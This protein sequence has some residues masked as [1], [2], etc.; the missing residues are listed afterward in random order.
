MTCV[1]LTGRHPDDRVAG[2]WRDLLVWICA[3]CDRFEYRLPVRDCPPE[4]DCSERQPTA[5]RREDQGEG[6]GMGPVESEQPT[7]ISVVIETTG[8]MFSPRTRT[9]EVISQ[10]RYE[11]PWLEYAKAMRQKEDIHPKAAA[12]PCPPHGV[13][14]CGRCWP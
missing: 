6:S 7:P 1:N 2:R 13:P 5:T 9:W 12:I 14:Y 3:R 4:I 11:M 8:S 10:G